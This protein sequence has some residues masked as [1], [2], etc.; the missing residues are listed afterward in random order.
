LQNSLADTILQNISKAQKEIDKLEAES[1]PTNAITGTKDIARK[2]SQKNEGVNDHGSSSTNKH[3]AKV[4]T[5]AELAQEKDA[6]ND[7]AAGLEKAKIDD[8]VES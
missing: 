7:T 6:V 5:G 3:G 2:P 1:T 4:D 8:D